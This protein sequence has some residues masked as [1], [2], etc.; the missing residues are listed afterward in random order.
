M[1]FIVM[2]RDCSKISFNFIV[3]YCLLMVNQIVV[4]TLCGTPASG[5]TTFCKQLSKELSQIATVFYL[6]FDVVENTINEL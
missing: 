2:K 1:V 5:K 3:N 6:S 4:V